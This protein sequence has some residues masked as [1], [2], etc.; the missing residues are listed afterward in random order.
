[1]RFALMIEPQQGVTWEQNLAIAQHAEAAGFGTLYRSDHYESFPGP[2]A[3]PSTDAW[4]TIAGL[5]RETT[6][7][8][9]GTMVSPVTFRHPSNLAKVVATIDE[10]SGGRV[11]LGIGAGW[12][13]DEHRRHGFEF[14]D[15]ISRIEMMEE[16][17][18]IV[19]GLWTG[20]NGWSFKGLHYQVEDAHFAPAPVQQPRP[21]IIVG[22]RGYERGLRAAARWSDHLNL[23]T[24][25]PAGVAEALER[26]GP[27]CEEQGRDPD[28]ITRSVLCSVAIGADRAEADER[29]AD[30]AKTL[31]FDSV[32]D[33]QAVAGPSWATGTPDEALARFREYEDAGAEVIL[34]QDFLPYDLDHIDLLGA[35]AREWSD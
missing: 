21:P 5:V 19:S 6:T 35:L 4:A 16:Q 24:L 18:Q 7:L 22:T 2:A 10:M 20:D 8:R 23:Y 29:Q 3:E 33:W 1:M 32:S 9:H 27:V 25:D 12:H 15:R 30:V 17:L 34:L 28:E 14:H 26:F 31:G 13:E 11:E